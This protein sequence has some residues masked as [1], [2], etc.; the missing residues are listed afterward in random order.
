MAI[1]NVYKQTINVLKM[2]SDS[3]QVHTNRAKKPVAP[4]W[5]EYCT[6]SHECAREAFLM[7]MPNGK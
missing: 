6:E 1:D 3:T 7:W 4:K 2:A 5:N